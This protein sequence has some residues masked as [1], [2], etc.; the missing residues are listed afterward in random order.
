LNFNQSDRDLLPSEDL[1]VRARLF[2]HEALSEIHDRYYPEV[3]RYIRFRVDEEALVEDLTS[4]VFLR[5]LDS[6]RSK[7]GPDRNLRG[8]LMGTASN[9]VNDH[10]RKSYRRKEK[11]LDDNSKEQ[12]V[13]PG[14]P[15]TIWENLQVQKQIRA[16][17]GKLTQ[18]QQHVLALRFADEYS[19]EETAQLIG[20]K[21][22]AVKALQFRALASLRRFLA[23]ERR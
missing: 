7:R 23:E 5:F 20:K 18:E 6:L 12:L 11:E 15:E 19:L 14:S 9:L 13:E 16:A 21:V 10:F 1:L 8:W 2:D 3:F 4:E 17:L 22:N